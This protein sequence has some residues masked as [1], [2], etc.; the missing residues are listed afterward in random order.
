MDLI[1][2]FYLQSW[3]TQL[4]EYKILLDKITN[5]RQLCMSQLQATE[6]KVSCMHYCIVS[7]NQQYYYIMYNNVS[8]AM[9]KEIKKVCQDCL[10]KPE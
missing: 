10:K 8:F 4:Q 9:S 5:E 2:L 3:E 7:S 1:V 6:T